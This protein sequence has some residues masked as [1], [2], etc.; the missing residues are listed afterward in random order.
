MNLTNLNDFLFAQL[1]RVNNEE[2]TDEELDNAIKRADT[3][4][5]I[6][7]QIIKTSELQYK[8]L[9]KGIE[10]GIVT[11]TQIQALLPVNDKDE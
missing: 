5:K 10:C 7:E 8:V 9:C 11:N 1:E 3:V 4:A 6:S 2:I